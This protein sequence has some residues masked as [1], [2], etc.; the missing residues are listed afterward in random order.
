MLIDQ[1]M[2]II[3]MFVLIIQDIF[4]IASKV[5]FTSTVNNVAAIVARGAT[6]KAG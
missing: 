6:R 3:I 5:Q 1:I 2:T 4:S